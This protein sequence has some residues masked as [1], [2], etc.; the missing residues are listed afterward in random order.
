MRYLEEKTSIVST[1]IENQFPQHVQENNPLFLNFL[2]EYYK[3]QEGKYGPLD[4]AA[5][6]TDYYNITYFRPNRLVEFV[7]LTSDISDSDTTIPVFSTKGYPEKG[8]I[9]I[10]DE[11]VYYEDKTNNSFTNCIRGTKALVLSN[12]PKSLVTLETSVKSSH[13]AKVNVYNIAYNYAKEFFNRIKSEI[14]VQIPEVLD[15]SL[16]VGEFLK[17]IKSFY[18]AKGSLNSHRIVFRI[19]F[20]DRR[21]D[22]KLKTRGT[23][24]VLDIPN[25][26]GSIPDPTTFQIPDSVFI[27][28]GG[29]GYDNRK[30]TTQGALVNAPVPVVLFDII[31]YFEALIVG[32]LY[33]LTIIFQYLISYNKRYPK[34]IK[35]FA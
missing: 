9:K 25:L 35:L 26:D 24:A 15:E 27:K 14:G 2:S 8:Y 30:V 12:I 13:L 18:S 31:P 4:I 16:D 21:F 22:L 23:G 28:N 34:Y 5:N 7:E 32:I 6:L 3:S 33:I 17:K 29:S 1:I 11:I 10:D 20:N 19:L